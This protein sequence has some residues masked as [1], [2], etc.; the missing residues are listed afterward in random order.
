MA[1]KYQWIGAG[2]DSDSNMA[3]LTNWWLPR[4]EMCRAGFVSLSSGAAGGEG[5]VPPG[6]TTR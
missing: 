4:R 1:G 6:N 3:A 2:R 5:D